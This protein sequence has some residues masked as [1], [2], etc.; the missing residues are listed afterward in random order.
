MEIIHNLVDNIE[1]W[2]I[3]GVFDI[4]ARLSEGPQR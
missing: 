2:N 1:L 4:N 3:A